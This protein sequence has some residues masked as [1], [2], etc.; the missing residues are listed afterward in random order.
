MKEKIKNFC[1]SLKR[2]GWKTEIRRIMNYIRFRKTV[3]DSYKEWQILN[4]PSQKD[5]EMQKKYES[6]LKIKFLVIV[7]DE[8][9][10]SGLQEQTYSHFTVKCAKSKEYEKIIQEEENIDYV[11]FVGNHIH[12]YP[13][14][15][16]NIVKYLEY[17]DCYAFYT[18]NDEYSE[19]KGKRENPD[20][21]PDFAYD[22]LLSKNYI[23]N[24]IGIKKNFLMKYTDILKNIA[25]EDPFYDI[26][27][28]MTEILSRPNQIFHIDQVLYG[29]KAEENIQEDVQKRVIA[30]HFQR[31]HIL[32]EAIENGK[33]PGQYHIVY[34]LKEE[35]PKVSIV[36]PNMDHINDLKTTVESIMN[37]STYTNIEIVI[38]EN[39]SKNKETFV[40]YEELKKKYDCVHVEKL[41]I[42]YFNY[43]R[44][45]NFGVEKATGEYIILLNN[46]VEIITPNWIEEMLMYVEQKRVGI[47][48]A[49]LYFPDRSIQHAGVTIGI[50]GLAGHRYHELPESAFTAKDAVSYVQDLSAVT[51]ACFMIAKENYEKVLGFDEKLAVAFN[52][53]D[54]CLKILQED[55]QIIYNPF[56]EL[57]HYESKSRGQDDSEE[58]QKRFAGEYELFVKRWCKEIQRG[59]RYFN[60][61]YRLDTDIPTINY[62]RI[63]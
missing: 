48:G 1:H 60:I 58:K 49:R 16:Y 3:P 33:F 22:T 20:F 44:I 62:N 19:E 18:D 41:E 35:K 34:S 10:I 47:C 61:N 46:D 39:N 7:D 57:Y 55:L 15:L 40:Y 23:G 31:K 51:A 27:L 59:D 32:Y 54:F 2:N 37:K 63:R 8:K 9:S 25:Q 36:I 4:E 28:R 13:F 38:V 45:V 21:K 14:A 50:R 52:D 42:T 30:E 43:S 11:L 24:F 6:C 12:M 5:L 56:V 53:V 26:L 29:K 17:N